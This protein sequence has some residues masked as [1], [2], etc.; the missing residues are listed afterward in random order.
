ML[1]I[2]GKNIETI[3]HNG[4]RI[5]ALYKGGKLIWTNVQCC[6][7]K[8]GWRGDKPWVGSQAWE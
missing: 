8:Q 4:K 6:F 2:N 5:E 7:G 3:I 1:I